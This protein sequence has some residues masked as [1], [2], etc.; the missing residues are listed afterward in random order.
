MSR[1]GENPQIPSAPASIYVQMVLPDHINKTHN[2]KRAEVSQQAYPQHN[3][4]SK[5]Q[6]Q[7]HMRPKTNL[8][9]ATKS[10]QSLQ[11]NANVKICESP[12]TQMGKIKPFYL[13]RSRRVGQ[14]FSRKACGARSP[15]Q[16]KK[17]ARNSFAPNVQK[18]QLICRVHTAAQKC[19]KDEIPVKL[20]IVIAVLS[21]L[22][23]LLLN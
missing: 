20:L 3:F 1:A 11:S 7:A 21:L 23:R 4:Y 13:P 9:E 8:L 12:R 17:H 5:N 22:R 18:R 16:F 10:L 19:R 2:K 6:T 15:R 14:L